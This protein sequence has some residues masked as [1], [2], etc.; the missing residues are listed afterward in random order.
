MSNNLFGRVWYEFSELSLSG[1]CFLLW[2]KINQVLKENCPLGCPCPDYNCTI[3]AEMAILVLATAKSTNVPIL[4]LP[5]G[6]KDYFGPYLK[7]FLILR[8]NRRRFGI[9]VGGRNPSLSFMFSNFEQSNVCLWWVKLEKTGL[10]IIR[11][12]KVI[13]T[14]TYFW[15]M[16]QIFILRFLR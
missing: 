2:V 12:S 11:V 10:S 6:S 1:I 5:N 3:E 4:L 8:W 15:R 13:I 7:N 14:V 16:F 9:Q